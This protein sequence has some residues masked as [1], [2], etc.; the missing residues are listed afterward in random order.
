[1]RHALQ[2]ENECND[3]E[4]ADANC[5][6]REVNGDPGKSESL[7]NSPTGREASITPLHSDGENDL[8][9]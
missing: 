6:E 3:G 5:N 7:R 8:S 4:F 1:M 2:R 9:Y